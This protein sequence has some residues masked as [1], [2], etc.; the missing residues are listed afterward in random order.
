MKSVQLNVSFICIIY[1][2][3]ENVK[4]KIKNYFFSFQRV[5]VYSVEQLVW[6][7]MNLSRTG[8]QF[9]IDRIELLLMSNLL[10]NK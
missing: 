1:R 7:K 9:K 5:P 6:S 3:V 2:L 10:E 8:L 4:C